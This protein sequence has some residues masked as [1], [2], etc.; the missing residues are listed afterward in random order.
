MKRH[1]TITLAKTVSDIGELESRFLEE[2]GE[3]TLDEEAEI[4]LDSAIKTGKIT[5][6]VAQDEEK[7]VGMCSVS[8]CFSTFACSDVAQYDD[9]F[10][11]PEYRHSGVARQLAEY[12]QKWCAENGIVSLTVTSSPMDEAMYQHLGFTL[13]LGTTYANV[14]E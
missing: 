9:F 3:D 6:F 8:R 2:I 13:R 14:I 12:A 1:A 4:R 11:L 7:P 5:F 10:V